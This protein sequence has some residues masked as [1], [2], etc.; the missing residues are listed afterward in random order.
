MAHAL[1]SPKEPP[2]FHVERPNGSSSFVLTADHASNRVPAQLGDLGLSAPE[3][4]RHIGWDIGI[5]RVGHYL[6][7]ALDACLVMQQYSRLVIDCNRPPGSPGSVLEV[8]E[9]T[10]IPGNES[11]TD[12]Q[13]KL[14]ESEVFWPYHNRIRAAL[15]ER[16]ARGQRSV[17]IALHSFT[18]DYMDERRSVEIGVLFERDARLAEPLLRL[19]RAEPELN[20]GENAPYAMSLSTDFTMTTHAIDRGFLHV[21]LEIRQDLIGED[22]QCAAWAQRLA[23]WLPAALELADL[24][25]KA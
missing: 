6:S 2:S 5:A 7:E 20:V 4:A 8:S 24:A 18:P 16:S 12:E 9:R 17:M 21:E 25:D 22:A 23:R 13:R 14:R 11:V 1:L 15:D 19:L 3:L 10:R